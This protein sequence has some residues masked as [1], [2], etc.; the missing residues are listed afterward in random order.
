MREQSLEFSFAREVVVLFLKRQKVVDDDCVLDAKSIKVDSIDA[1]L[2]QLIRLLVEELVEA[3][4]L[5]S[6]GGSS[7]KEPAVA[8]RP[9]K[10]ILGRDAV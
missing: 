3:L 9:L 4:R 7:C 1:L 8:K 10:D 6:K 2:A 5:L